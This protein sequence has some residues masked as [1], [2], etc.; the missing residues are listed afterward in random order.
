MGTIGLNWQT[1]GTG[2][3]SSNPV[4]TDLMMR[5]ANTG[6]FEVYDIGNN[7]IR[8]AFSLGTMSALPR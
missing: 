2:D 4:E 1:L 3:F 5:D 8:S 7:Q 6:A